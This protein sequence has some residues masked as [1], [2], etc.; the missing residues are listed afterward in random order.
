MASGTAIGFFAMPAAMCMKARTWMG[1][2]SQA[3][4]KDTKEGAE[5][6]YMDSIVFKFTPTNIPNSLFMGN[7]G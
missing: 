2:G 7:V 5:D 3:G 4:G 6:P 1:R